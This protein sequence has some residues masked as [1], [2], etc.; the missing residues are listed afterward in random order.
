MIRMKNLYAVL[1]VGGGP[2]GSVLARSLATQGWKV[3]LLE[4]NDYSRPRVGETFS[5]QLL[6][7]MDQLG[8][9]NAFEA[10]PQVETY[11]TQSF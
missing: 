6:P 3:L 9:R 5:P 1:I 2:A 10:L 7:M 4:G 11:G 8:L